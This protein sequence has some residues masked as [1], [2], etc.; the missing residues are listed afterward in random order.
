[1]KNEI[2]SEATICW[3]LKLVHNPTHPP[4]MMTFFLQKWMTVDLHFSPNSLSG[5]WVFMS[6]E[7]DQGRYCIS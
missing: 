6:K 3:P 4:E 5:A 1:M 2:N 7:G